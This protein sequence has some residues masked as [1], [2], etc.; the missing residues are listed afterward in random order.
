M[1]FKSPKNWQTRLGRPRTSRM[2]LCLSKVVRGKFAAGVVLASFIIGLFFS[3]VFYPAT[4]RA[5]GLSPALPA[6]LVSSSSFGPPGFS[7][8]VSVVDKALAALRKA[9]FGVEAAERLTKQSIFDAWAI[10]FKTSLRYF[11]NTLAYDTATWLASGG[12]GQTKKKR[13]GVAGFEFYLYAKFIFF[14][15]KRNFDEPHKIETEEDNHHSSD[16]R[17][18]CLHV[19]GDTF[20]ESI[21]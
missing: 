17:E 21:E 7:A 11:L 19:I 10:A 20:K 14:F 12:K 2:T 6:S 18:P 4:A 15:Q 5:L 1:K 8:D 9:I 16:A 3:A 13:R